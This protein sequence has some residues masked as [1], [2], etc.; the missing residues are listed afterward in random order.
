MNF[1]FHTS[2]SFYCSELKK[3]DSRYPNQFSNISL[4]TL[5]SQQTFKKKLKALKELSRELRL[6]IAET[7]E[8]PKAIASMLQSLNLTSGFLVSMKNL[9]DA[10]EI[11]TEKDFE[12]IEKKFA[13]VKV[14][15]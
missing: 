3:S 7:E 12:D 6:R 10:K 2:F 13:E 9:P 15:A 1:V 8:R 5:L 4:L 14:G 11:Y